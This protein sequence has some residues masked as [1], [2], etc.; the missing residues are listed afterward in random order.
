MEDIFISINLLVAIKLR[1]NELLTKQITDRKFLKNFE[2]S[3]LIYAF[4]LR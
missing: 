3:L 2:G 4:F 1:H